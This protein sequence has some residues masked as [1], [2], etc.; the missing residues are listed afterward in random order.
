MKKILKY[1][2]RT[3]KKID[4]L[5]RIYLIGC[6]ARWGVMELP[7]A[8]FDKN[9]NPLVYNYNDHNGTADQWELIPLEYT[10]TGYVYDWTFNKENAE[11]IAALLNERD[12]TK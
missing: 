1:N 5:P 7:F 4:S 10:T 2:D 3:R 8:E 11:K 6:W 12:N 9:R